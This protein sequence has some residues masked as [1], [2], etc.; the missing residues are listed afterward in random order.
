MVNVVVSDTGIG[1]DAEL[2]PY[3]FDRFRQA[4]SS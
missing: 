4:D 3:I 1:I 2:L